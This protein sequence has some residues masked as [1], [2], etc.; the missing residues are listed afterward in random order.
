MNVRGRPYDEEPGIRPH[1]EGVSTGSGPSVTRQVFTFFA[2]AGLAILVAL[3]ITALLRVF[4]FQVFRVPSG[5]ME[6]TLE[7]RD[8][9]V[10]VRLTDYQRG[11]IVVF[12]DPP[13][14]WMGPQPAASD[15]VRRTLEALQLLPD[16]TQGY[17]VKRVIGLPGDHVRCCDQS[18][19]INVNGVALDEQDYLYRD[20]AGQPV[21]PSGIPFD[22]VVPSGHLFV[23]GDH[24]DRSA[25][26]RLHLCEQTDA[27]VPAGMNGF[28]PQANV[29]GPVTTIVLPPGRWRSFSTPDTFAAIPAGQDAP[30]APV[31]GEG[32]C[33]QP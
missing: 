23:M 33:S 8:R 28:I 11:D 13:A 1:V 14:Q 30:L 17:L 27:G 22:I 20:A 24:R 5:S 32:T 25:D 4:I 18:Q 7:Q 19:R 9:I 16:S 15:P 21:A 3:V 2:E 31:I 26:S 10:A 12:E 29:I 6:N